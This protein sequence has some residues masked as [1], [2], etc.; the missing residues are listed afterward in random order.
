[1]P[2][3]AATDFRVWLRIPPPRGP[4]SAASNQWLRRWSP[5]IPPPCPQRSF[6]HTPD[7]GAQTFYSAIANV[8]L[9]H[10]A[11]RR[12]RRTPAVNARPLPAA[13]IH[14]LGAP[15]RL[16][17]VWPPILHRGRCAGGGIG[18]G[19]PAGGAR[20]AAWS[21][22]RDSCSIRRSRGWRTTWLLLLTRERARDA[23]NL[24]L[25]FRRRL[26]HCPAH[27]RLRLSTRSASQPPL[28]PPS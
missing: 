26:V 2:Q 24:H 21:R 5:S 8:R 12:R 3:L 25:R 1:M 9:A 18:W 22:N 13:A 17:R 28:P 15:Q 16:G 10:G 11:H 19:R 27:C 20:W 14:R 4:P 23:I 7:L 6:K